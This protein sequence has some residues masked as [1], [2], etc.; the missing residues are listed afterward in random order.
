MSVCVCVC[1]WCAVCCV[2]GVWCA[3][4]CVFGMWCA[5]VCLWYEVCGLCVC[6]TWCVCTEWV[7]V[8]SVMC[9]MSRV[10]VCVCV[11]VCLGAKDGCVGADQSP[12]SGCVA[13]HLLGCL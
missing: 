12:L 10:C 4:C 3:V 11:C 5:C 6:G 9:C 8:G 1:V 13:L 7:C 2:F